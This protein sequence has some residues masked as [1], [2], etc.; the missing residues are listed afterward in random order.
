[1]NRFFNCAAH[2]ALCV[3]ICLLIFGG[4]AAPT[5]SV[6]ADDDRPAADPCGGPQVC[7]ISC[8]G[9]FPQCGGQQGPCNLA[10]LSCSGCKCKMTADFQRCEC[11]FF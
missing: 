1:M 8:S 4:L 3:A 2:L 6:F 11:T 5:S 7:N 9:S 10:P